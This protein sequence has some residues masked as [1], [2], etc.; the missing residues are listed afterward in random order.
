MSCKYETPLLTTDR[1][2]S[3]TPTFSQLFLLFA[4]VRLH[5]LQIPVW[6]VSP[7]QWR[8][9]P[10]TVSAPPPLLMW[11][12]QRSA[13]A[14]W[15][16]SSSS[17]PLCVYENATS[18]RRSTGPAAC[19][20]P[21]ATS[22]LYPKAWW[23]KLRSALPWR[24]ALWLALY[25]I[26]TTVLSVHSNLVNSGSSSLRWD[27]GLRGLRV[28]WF[29]AW[30]PIYL[31]HPPPALT[32]TLLG[33]TIGSMTT[34][35]RTTVLLIL[36]PA[37]TGSSLNLEFSHIMKDERGGG[38]IAACACAGQ[39]KSMCGSYSIISSVFCN[40]ESFSTWSFP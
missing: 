32:T 8:G 27:P 28:L 22:Q 34:K 20:I 15:G 24:S 19:K 31:L 18:A 36:F 3:H 17:W 25:V 9:T 26:R 23:K 7:V 29:A 39:W 16:L 21:T 30:P 38:Q 2:L 12:S 11:K 40:T 1:E 10:S 14:Y 13:Q 5:A 33:K 35:V 6:M 37:S 4:D